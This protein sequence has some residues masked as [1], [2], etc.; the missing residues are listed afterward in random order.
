MDAEE[1]S[2][3]VKRRDIQLKIWQPEDYSVAEKGKPV[4]PAAP[5]EGRKTVTQ[6]GSLRPPK[7]CRA[8]FFCL[9]SEKTWQ[10]NTVQSSAGEIQRGVKWQ[11]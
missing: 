6:A 1:E 2:F 4:G 5:Q 8:F 7:T 10:T 3:R 11:Q 9:V